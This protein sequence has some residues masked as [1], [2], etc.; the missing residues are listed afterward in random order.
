[1]DF[2]RIHVCMERK[3]YKQDIIRNTCNP[4]FSGGQERRIMSLRAAQS[5]LASP[6]LKNKTK[7]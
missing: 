1:M 5:E 3:E 4:T 2:I 6:Y 7:A